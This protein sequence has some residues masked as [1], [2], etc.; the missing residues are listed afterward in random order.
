VEDEPL[1]HQ[2]YIDL[3]QQT[4]PDPSERNQVTYDIE[5][6]WIAAIVS[7][8]ATQRTGR[9]GRS[10]RYDRMFLRSMKW[11]AKEV[12][13]LG[14]TPNKDILSYKGRPIFLSDHFGLFSTLNF[15]EQ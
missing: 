2:G 12:H 3:W 1:V 9:Q 15:T 11:V 14:N 4:H 6:N 10:F 7:A 5:N 8:Q 13:L